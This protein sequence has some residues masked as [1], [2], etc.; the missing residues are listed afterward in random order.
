MDPITA[1]QRLQQKPRHIRQRIL[2]ASV[3]ISMTIIVVSWLMITSRRIDGDIINDPNKKVQTET[4]ASP[5]NMLKKT[6]IDAMND[7]RTKF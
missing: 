1:I 7:I 6:F 5:F 4:A 3:A 2:F